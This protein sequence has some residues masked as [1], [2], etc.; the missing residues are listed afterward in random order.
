MQEPIIKIQNIS[1]EYK[2]GVI[3]AK[4]L[5]E[6]F[7]SLSAKLRGKENPNLKI[8][9]SSKKGTFKA[10]DNV[11]FDIYKG[12]TIGIIGRNGA[13]KS[14]LLK[15][16]SKITSPTDGKIYVKGRI[17]SMLEIG[18]GFHPELT[19][20]ENIYLNGAILGMTKSEINRKL[21]EIIEFS[22]CEEF[23]NTPV[24]RYSSG[25]YVKLAFSVAAHLSSEILIMDEVLA[26][27]DAAFSQKCINKM[28]SLAKQENR[29]ILYVSHN[30][31]TVE[32]LCSRAVV[33][34][35][36]KVSY[37]GDTESAINMYL[38]SRENTSYNMYFTPDSNLLKNISPIEPIFVSYTR[39]SIDFSHSEPL[40]ITFNWFN[41]KDIKNLCM[42]LTIYNFQKHPIATSVCNN[43]YSGSAGEKSK[44]TLSF[45]ISSLSPGKYETR[46]TFFYLSGNIH[47]I[48]SA[49]G[50]SFNKIQTPNSSDIKWFNKIFGNVCLP[51]PTIK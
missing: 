43:F 48:F 15:I 19:G 41:K 26:V 51:P 36:G 32:K 11:S 33:L 12:E 8:G 29:T 2:L 6:E 23:I 9:V 45:D 31:S 21:E 30:M 3:G 39:K 28:L 18:T 50:L 35:K 42:R 4:T 27:G 10:L 34:D 25:M 5:H 37:I 20:L 49:S 7:Q 17:S 47:D 16:L 44:I 22:E 13:G 24:K 14:T 38:S 1:K 46:Y 40:E